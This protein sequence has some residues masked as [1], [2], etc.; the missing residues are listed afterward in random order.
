M[1]H[2]SFPAPQHFIAL[3]C[4][5]H[6]NVLFDASEGYDIVLWWLVR[7][8]LLLLS[9]RHAQC[10]MASGITFKAAQCPKYIV[11]CVLGDGVCMQGI[12]ITH[13]FSDS[14]NCIH[15]C[16]DLMPLTGDGSS[17]N[18]LHDVDTDSMAFK[19]FVYLMWLARRQ[20]FQLKGYGAQQG[21]AFR[22]GDVV[23]VSLV[24]LKNLAGRA[25]VEHQFVLSR[26]YC[27]E[28][29]IASA[30]CHGVGRFGF[31]GG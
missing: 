23:Q 21:L 11:P 5:A 14:A 31:D 4:K 13:S 6:F 12:I 19:E 26:V 22:P 16:T 15:K 2:A 27:N 30:D 25:T 3:H 18:S 10:I 20:F 24:L 29:Q 17:H 7:Q 9:C 8:V 28:N 1:T